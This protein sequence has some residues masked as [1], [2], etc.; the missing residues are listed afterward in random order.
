[1][2]AAGNRPIR[3]GGLLLSLALVGG[4]LAGC[5]SDGRETVRFAFAKP[6]AIPY[7]RELV[8]TYNA[9][10]D[11]VNVILDTSGVD[12]F[13]AGF[14]RGDPPD[15]GLNNYNQETARFIQRCAMSDISDTQAAQSVREDLKPFMDQFGVCPGRTSAIPYSIMG[16]AVIYNVQIFEDNDLEV[17]TTWDEL[18][19]VCETLEAAGV[20]PFYATFADNWTIGQGWYD[21]SVG[22]MIDT[23][24][25]FEDLAEEG[26]NVGPDSPVS[27]QK[28]QAEPVD[29]MLELAQYVNSDAPSRTYGDGNTAMAKG[30]GAMYMQGPWAF[31]EIA[32]AAPD[33]ELGMFPLPVTNDPDDLKA[34][35]NMDLA[36]WIPEASEHKEAAREFLEYLYQPEIIQSYNESQLGF[37][38]TKNAPPVTDPRIIGLQEYIDAGE[39]YQGSTQLVP[40][41]IPIM[42]YTQAIML[43]SDPQRI[44]SNIDADY[45][46]LA[47][48][49]Q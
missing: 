22:G 45:A 1:M 36:A 43:G 2:P 16:A 25:F 6:E 38:P 26:V 23:L 44:L 17:P 49:Q 48:R 30:E 29:K 10:Q 39:M 37:L 42:N 18:I 28:D 32:K 9:S 19:E 41:A 14:V 7:M 8:K 5:S 12:A 4:G 13:S 35:I 40:R 20:T 24:A 46:R 11:E 27:F 34:R 33:L 3:I 15:I 31:G 47:Y 21:Y